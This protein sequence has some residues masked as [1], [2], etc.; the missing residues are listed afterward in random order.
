MIVSPFEPFVGQHCETTTNGSLLNQL[1]IHLTEP[2]LFGLGEGLGFIYWH[3]KS[4]PHPFIGGRVKPFE[5]TRTLV[6]NLGLQL[7]V[8]ETA[9][10]KKAWQNLHDAL[11]NNR[12]AGL[13]L[14]CY[15]L[16]Y[17]TNK[18]HFAGH[19]AAV[20]GY[21]D[22]D[23]YLID[24]AQ[25]GGRVKTSLESLAL[26]RSE[27]G[28][29]AAKNR[30]YVIDGHTDAQQITQALQPAIVN[31]ANEY[32]NPPI[33]N[34]GYKGIKKT[35]TEL[36]PWFRNSSAGGTSEQEF[37]TTAMLMERAG[38]GGALFRNMY[39]DF[40]QESSELLDSKALLNAS[41]EFAVIAELWTDVAGL[42]DKAAVTQDEHPVSEACGILNEI[43][44]LEF[45]SMS[46]LAK[47]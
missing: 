2:M 33:R 22:H 5:L 35:A 45:Q 44:D 12:A 26:A 23:C 47:L 34:F 20:Y 25:Q 32:L 36:L 41:R 6:R 28:P 29:M 17:F 7:D 21:D 37:Q 9:S 42:L 38:T 31:N 10:A 13:Q 15:H 30:L 43:S 24:T 14:D 4:M 1:G 8:K 46:A 18:V 27:K 40:L 3:M 19:F 39:R 16:E 11:A